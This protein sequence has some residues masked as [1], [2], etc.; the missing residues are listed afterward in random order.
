MH[1]IVNNID[2]CMYMY[3]YEERGYACVCSGHYNYVTCV[4][5]LIGIKLP[6]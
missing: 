6:G 2:E 3:V 4:C 1:I 5:Q